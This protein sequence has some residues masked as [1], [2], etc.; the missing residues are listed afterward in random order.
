MCS[1]DSA[2]SFPCLCSADF[3]SLHNC[4][5]FSLH[6][7]PEFFLALQGQLVGNDSISSRPGLGHEGMLGLA[8]SNNQAP[9]Q[10]GAGVQGSGAHEGN[11]EDMEGSSESDGASVAESTAAETAD[12]DRDLDDPP[13]IEP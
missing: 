7:V 10:V 2:G 1:A 5:A 9:E 4:S 8:K 13:D 6:R 3:W 11:D 12:L